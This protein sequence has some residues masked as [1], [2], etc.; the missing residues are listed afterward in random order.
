MEAALLVRGQLPPALRL[1]KAPDV[2]DLKQCGSC[3][4]HLDRATQF[5]RSKKSKDGKQGYCRVCNMAYQR[6][7]KEQRAQPTEAEA[8]QIARS[9]GLMRQPRKGAAKDRLGSFI[10]LERPEQEVAD[11]CERWWLI[12]LQ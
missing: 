12:V 9:K 7:V 1:G 11:E 8:M 6:A 3:R 4:R 10:H 2:A 5:S